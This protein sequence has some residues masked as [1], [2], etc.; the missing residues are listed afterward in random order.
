MMA[1]GTHEPT[2]PPGVDVD[3]REDGLLW[4]IN[5]VVFHPRGFA[6]GVD[7]DDDGR[8]TGRFVLFGDGTEVWRFDLDEDARF[9][10]V[11]RCLDRAR[12]ANREGV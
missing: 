12:I 11:A 10:R 4:L 9:E 2:T 5:R 7:V 1:D 6:L 3:L 8:P